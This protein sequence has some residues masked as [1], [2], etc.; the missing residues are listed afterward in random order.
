[1]VVV[2][3]GVGCHSPET[4]LVEV[5]W[6]GAEGGEGGGGNHLCSTWEDEEF[7]IGGEGVQC[8]CYSG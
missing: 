2:R 5:R 7:E 4:L 8:P 1:M 6:L 3:G